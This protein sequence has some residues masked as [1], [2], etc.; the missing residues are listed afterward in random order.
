MF[1]NK[2]YITQ[3]KRCYDGVDDDDYDDGENKF[4]S[5]LFFARRKNSPSH[6]LLLSRYGG[7]V[8]SKEE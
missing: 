6:L 5:T 8:R 7:N 2:I 1:P 3:S 4:E